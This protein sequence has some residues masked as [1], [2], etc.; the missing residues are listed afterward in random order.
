MSC[1]SKG[2]ARLVRAGRSGVAGGLRK[3]TH[4]FGLPGE[5]LVFPAGAEVQ[6]HGILGAFVPTGTRRRCQPGESPAG[7]LRA[8]LRVVLAIS[9]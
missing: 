1:P 2:G 6:K 7:Q 3:P 4:F 5:D 8:V 9:P